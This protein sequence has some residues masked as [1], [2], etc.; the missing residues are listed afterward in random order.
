MKGGGREE[1][2]ERCKG[3]SFPSITDPTAP[4]TSK[5]KTETQKIGKKRWESKH[6]KGEEKA[7]EYKIY[8]WD[9][10]IGD[11]MDIRQEEDIRIGTWN[12]RKQATLGLE[13][14]E[15]QA[16]I[17]IV[18]DYMRSMD[19]QIMA[20]QETGRGQE[21]ARA[22]EKAV[23]SREYKAYANPNKGGLAIIIHKKNRCT[24]I[25]STNRPKRRIYGT[26]PTTNIGRRIQK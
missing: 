17:E 20:L 8:E 19:I 2:G 14:E 25:K 18:M 9:K 1:E 11:Q 4:I 22:I 10:L 26:T 16:K 13:S 24:Q 23:N 21:K 3:M 12:I 5:T 7:N 15:L 6:E